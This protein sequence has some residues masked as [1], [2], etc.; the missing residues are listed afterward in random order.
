MVYVT[1]CSLA[2][3]GRLYLTLWSRFV[4]RNTRFELR[5]VHKLLLLIFDKI[6]NNLK[7]VFSKM[8]QIL[9]LFETSTY[10]RVEPH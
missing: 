7:C 9:L 8:G 2:E 4:K 10:F 6:T 1:D 3:S 5:I